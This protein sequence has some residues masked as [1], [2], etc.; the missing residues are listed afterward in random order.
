MSVNSR[1]FNLI[2]LSFNTYFTYSFF[3]IEDKN[4]LNSTLLWLYILAQEY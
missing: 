3:Q 4:T 1:T 2:I